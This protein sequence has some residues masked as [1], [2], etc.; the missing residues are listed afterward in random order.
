MCSVSLLQ[1][2]LFLRGNG[3]NGESQFGVVL[4]KAALGS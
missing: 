2:G 3:W 4:I 1:A